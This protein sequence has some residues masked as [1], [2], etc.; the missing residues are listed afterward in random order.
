ML[1]HM[2]FF[3]LQIVS[4]YQENKIIKSLRNKLVYKRHMS[5]TILMVVSFKKL[6]ISFIRHFFIF[7]HNCHKDTCFICFEEDHKNTC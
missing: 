3:F 6:N 1:G 2:V 7:D 5:S 4:I